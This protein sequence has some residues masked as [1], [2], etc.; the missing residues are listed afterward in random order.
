MTDLVLPLHIENKRPTA[1]RPANPRGLHGTLT[2]DEASPGAAPQ[3][4]HAT[5]RNQNYHTN[6]ICPLF[7]TRI[8]MGKPISMQ[9][10]AGFQSFTRLQP[11]SHELKGEFAKRTQLSFVFNK[12]CQTAPD[13]GLLSFPT[14]PSI[15]STRPSTVPSKEVSCISTSTVP[16]NAAIEGRVAFFDT[17][18]CL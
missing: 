17:R 10:T 18:N 3:V 9:R 6:P 15:N 12:T 4:P 7:S 14:D 2:S 1:I 8:Q 11:Q 5:N 16:K 13:A